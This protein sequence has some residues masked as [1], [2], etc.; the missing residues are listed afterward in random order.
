MATMTSSC[1]SQAVLWS[2]WNTN[3]WWFHTCRNETW[4]LIT[5]AMLINFIFNEKSSV[6]GTSED[7]QKKILFVSACLNTW[8]ELGSTPDSAEWTPKFI[9]SII[10]CH[11]AARGYKSV[12]YFASLDIH[13]VVSGRECESNLWLPYQI[14]CGPRREGRCV[15]QKRQKRNAKSL[16]LRVG[17]LE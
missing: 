6:H 17:T 2:H 11:I 8:H 1:L 5:D 3:T 13:M 12:P 10:Q 14:S 9:C 7:L 4:S 15:P 16:K